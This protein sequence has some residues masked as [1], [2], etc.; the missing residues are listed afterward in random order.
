MLMLSML[1]IFGSLRDASLSKKIFL[2]VVISL[3][4]ELSSRISGVISLRFD[5]DP[6]FSASAPTLVTL[7]IA[8]LLLRKKSS[9]L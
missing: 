3:F 2:G 7:A 8:F 4:F 9:N 6:L 1:F 5:Y